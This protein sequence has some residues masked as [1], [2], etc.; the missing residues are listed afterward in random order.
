MG[1]VIR[2]NYP[3][4]TVWNQRLTEKHLSHIKRHFPSGPATV[5]HWYSFYPSIIKQ[6]LPCSHIAEDLTQWDNTS[7]ATP[8][9]VA[10]LTL[11]LSVSVWTAL[12]LPWADLCTD[13][14][15]SRIGGLIMWVWLCWPGICF[16]T[17][18]QRAHK[19]MLL[20]SSDSLLV[21]VR[22]APRLR[23]QSLPGL[24]WRQRSFCA[25]LA[26]RHTTTL[27]GSTEHPGYYLLLWCQESTA[28]LVG[29]APCST[30]R[31][32]NWLVG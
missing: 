22:I 18:K 26:S 24:A 7:V 11:H 29:L 10:L 16:V 2:G 4:I 5:C 6:P 12:I 21:C 8:I 28:L 27:R 1:H 30:L 17:W 9:I 14:G 15:K 19:L 31:A 3:S 13:V 25:H 32:L 23:H 20:I